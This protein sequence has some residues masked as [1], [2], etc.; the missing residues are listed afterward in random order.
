MS[1][2]QALHQVRDAGDALAE[3]GVLA[4]PV[5]GLEAVR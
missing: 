2:R 3:A 4:A 1:M 5:R